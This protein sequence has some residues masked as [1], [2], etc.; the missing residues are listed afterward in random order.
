[1][2]FEHESNIG[3]PGS[4]AFSWHCRRGAFERLNPPWERVKVVDQ[5]EGAVENLGTVRFKI[6]TGPVWGD[7][8]ARHTEFSRGSRFADVQVAGPF[9][10]WRHEHRF[11][12]G[13]DGSCIL[14]DHIDYE[15]PVEPLGRWVAGGFV[16]R[17]LERM[18]RYRHRVTKSDLAQHLRHGAAPLSVAVTG[19]SGVLGSV[20]VPFLTTGGHRVFRLVRRKP[21]APDEIFWDPASS[22]IDAAALEGLDAVL[23]LAGENIGEGRFTEE[24]KRRA[25]SSRVLGTRLMAETLAKLVRPPRVFIS[26]SAVGYYGDRGDDFLDEDAPPG[27][28]FAADLC[29]AW[30]EAAAP[31]R[32]AGI[33][34]AHLRIG[35]VLTPAGG[36]LAK[37][38]VPSRLGL[39]GHMGNGRQ[40]ISWVSPDDVAG[41]VLHVMTSPRISGPVNLVAPRAATSR[42][43]AAAVARAFR[44]PA[45]FSVPAP[46]LRAAFGELAD[47][48]ILASA[49]VTP[50]VLAATGYRY[51]FP[52]LPSAL[53]HVLGSGG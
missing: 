3:A 51:S 33:R 21:A 41:A 17:K 18:F 39:G 37:L 42:E 8:V 15:L 45:P 23:H 49:R 34:T 10:S 38:A 27:R 22:R 9:A 30:E 43:L 6:R 13:P 1:M 20:I 52:E 47:E 16:R 4:D 50:G 14:T 53:A 48:V 7:W 26:A 28:G 12:A 32:A 31:A 19:A 44:K 11:A 46:L 25:L 36:A 40:F 5:P 2:I 24:K 29:R 35:V